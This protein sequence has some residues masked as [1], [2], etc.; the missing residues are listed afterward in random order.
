ME[1]IYTK[2]IDSK[3][4]SFKFEEN[5]L[6][7]E[8]EVG[9]KYVT[10]IESNTTRMCLRLI[11]TQSNGENYIKITKTNDALELKI[12]YQGEIISILLEKY[13]SSAEEQLI[14]LTELL[15]MEKRKI[16][17]G[18]TSPDDWKSYNG[19]NTGYYVEVKF[20]IPREEVPIVLT[21]LHGTGCHWMT[22]GASSVYNLT[23]EGFS[24]Y[25][26]YPS[27]ISLDGMIGYKWHIQYIAYYKD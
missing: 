18:K 23:N 14:H 25:V 17:A 19:T 2:R 21:S 4:Y 16:V 24:I 12:D 7:V 11:L 5:N 1:S 10:C 6:I 8:K 3:Y 27:G 9:E 26:C 22:S 15:S 13:L 20:E